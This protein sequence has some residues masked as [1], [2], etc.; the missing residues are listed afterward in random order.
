EGLEDGG[1]VIGIDDGNGL[2]G[3]VQG[4]V[5][6]A[7]TAADL[8]RGVDGGTVAGQVVGDG[9]AGQL[10]LVDHQGQQERSGAARAVPTE[11]KQRRAGVE[12]PVIDG[13][14]IAAEGNGAGVVA[15]LEEEDASVG[16]AVQRRQ[17]DGAV[18]AEGE[19]AKGAGAVGQG[20]VAAGV[21]DQHPGRAI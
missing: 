15:R 14:G 19:V 12:G 1:V 18:A 5:V 10:E 6:D 20:V 13:Q 3:A 7:V 17:V 16:P 11:G 4:Q 8:R 2:A 9:V 21:V